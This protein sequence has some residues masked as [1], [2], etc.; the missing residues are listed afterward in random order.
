MDFSCRV[1]RE[2]DYSNTLVKWWKDW[3]WTEAPPKSMLPQDGTCGLMI[4]KG[5]I[6][7]CAGFVFLT[8]SKTAWVEYI[9][10]NF[11]YKESDR[12]EA[13]ELLITG[14]SLL[15]KERGYKHIFT[16]LKNKHLIMRYKNC[17]YIVADTGC[18][19]MV[20]NL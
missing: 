1:L 4:S 3:R 16:S 12:G 5:D 19:E 2:D 14:L 15:A 17:G 9:I 11:E 13:I 8:N 6:D 7:V 18:T 10:S 20:K